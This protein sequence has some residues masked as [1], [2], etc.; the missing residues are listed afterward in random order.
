MEHKANYNSFIRYGLLIIGF[1]GILFAVGDSFIPQEGN[2]FAATEDPEAFAELVTMEGFRFW[3]MRGLIGIP[4]ELI[5]TIA[6]FLGLMG[7]RY[8]KWA[9]WGMMLCVISDLFGTGFFMLTYFVF[10]EA[11]E[12]IMAGTTAAASVVSLEGVMPIMASGFVATTIGLGLFAWA[13]WK[14]NIFPKWSGW[15]VVVGWLLLLVQT[16]YV[17]QIL[18]NVIWGPATY[19][20]PP[21]AGTNFQSINQLSGLCR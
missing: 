21:I 10:P 6:L 16:S 1:A 12:L 7:T 14:T 11:G 4:M 3:A 5:G 8:E 17:I 13:I 15:V 9:F 2:M 20:W 18:G 19:G